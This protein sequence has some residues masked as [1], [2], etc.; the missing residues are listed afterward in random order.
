MSKKNLYNRRKIT[1]AF[2]FYL[3]Y[4]GPGKGLVKKVRH[5]E[6]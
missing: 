2:K 6:M 4:K 5:K 3:I 1:R